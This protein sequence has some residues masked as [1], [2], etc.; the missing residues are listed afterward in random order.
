[1][2]TMA[3]RNP[4]SWL[5]EF[6]AKKRYRQPE[7]QELLRTGPPNQPTFTCRVVFGPPSAVIEAQGQGLT[8]KAAKTAAALQAHS[9]LMAGSQALPKIIPVS[10]VQLRPEIIPDSSRLVRQIPP[11]DESPTT[12]PVAEYKFEKCK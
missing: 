1:M 5:S 6:C 3:D 11:P 8:L 12:S 10:P 7:F 4:I 9:K 2:S